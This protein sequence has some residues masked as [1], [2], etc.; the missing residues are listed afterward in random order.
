[1]NRIKQTVEDAVK[2]ALESE[3]VGNVE[4]ESL[5]Y[6]IK[7]RSEGDGLKHSPRSYQKSTKTREPIGDI[8]TGK[9]KRAYNKKPKTGDGSFS[10]KRVFTTSDEDIKAMR[11]FLSLWKKGNKLSEYQLSIVEGMEGKHATM[12]EEPEREN[13]LSVFK[14]A[15]TNILAP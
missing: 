7:I 3:G 14:A 8:G 11:H 13:L 5:S 2:K 4:I 1:M 9:Q 10:L 6:V 15:R 12:L